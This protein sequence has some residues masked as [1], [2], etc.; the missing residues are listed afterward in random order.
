MCCIRELKDE[1]ELVLGLLFEIF[2]T[3]A[4]RERLLLSSE[5]MLGSQFGGVY[6]IANYGAVL[7][8]TM[9][10]EGEI[11]LL[12]NAAWC[13]MA[14]LGNALSAYI[15]SICSSIAFDFG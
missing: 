10:M 13:T 4:N 3:P 7:Y 14:I 9:G 11:P 8:L 6:V 1:S 5:V 2:R 12:L 15:V